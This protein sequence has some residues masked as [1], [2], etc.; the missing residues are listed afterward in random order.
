M[1]ETKSFF[2]QLQIIYFS[3]FMGQVVIATIF[4]F[5]I[6]GETPNSDNLLQYIGI[7]IL[8]MNIS[9]STVLYSIRKKQGAQLKGSLIQR[10]EHFRV[11]SLI[12]WAML[13]G[14]NFAVVIFMF[15][16][17]RPFDLVFFALGLGA[18]ILT[19]PT[20][21]MIAKDYEL[22]NEM[23]RELRNAVRS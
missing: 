10:L 7:G 21:D 20:V 18:F 11:S 6:Q 23:E 1:N 15:I 16:D 17:K 13:E 19:R 14:A 5:L 12:R 22:P 4:Y 3:L 9:V 2:N 8:L